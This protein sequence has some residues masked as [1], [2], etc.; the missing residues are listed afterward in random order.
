MIGQSRIITL[1]TDFGDSHYV[2]EMKGAAKRVNP[3]ADVVDVTHS[4][5]KYN[6][7]GGAFVLSRVW[8]HFPRNSVHVAVVDPGVGS[9]RKALAIETDSCF[10]I[11]PDNGILRWALKDQAVARIVEL[12][13]AKVLRL[14]GLGGVSATF[15]GRDLFAPAAALITRGVDLDLLGPRAA[16][17]QALEIKEDAVVHVDG[18]GNIITTIARELA[19]GTRLRVT[20]AGRTY[21]AVAAGTFSDAPEGALIVLVGSHGLVEIDVNRGSAAALLGANAGD[22]IRVENAG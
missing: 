17:I 12:D 5:E 7:A 16:D 9:G 19:P 13:A 21:D 8:R 10:L 2:G 4:V 1:T 15:H 11:G 20:H 3:D 6:V 18:F 14:A 22:A